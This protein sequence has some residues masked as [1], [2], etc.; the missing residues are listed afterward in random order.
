[1][2]MRER[3]GGPSLL[4]LRLQGKQVRDNLHA[5]DVC[6]AVPAFYESPRVAAVYNLGGGMRVPREAPFTLTPAK[7]SP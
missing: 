7:W 2:S 1:M 5:Y 3:V 6:T 4:G